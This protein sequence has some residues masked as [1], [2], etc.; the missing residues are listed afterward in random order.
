[1]VL[2]SVVKQEP[3]D[4][5]ESLTM[6]ILFQTAKSARV[7]P[8]GLLIVCLS[9]LG[10]AGTAREVTEA[11]APAAVES[12]VDELHQ[13][14]SRD[15]IG[16]ILQDEE[17]RE[18]SAHLVGAAV[19]GAWDALT[20]EERA[21]R[22]AVA[23]EAYASKLAFT[24]AENWEHEVGPRLSRSF[25]SVLDDSLV[26]LMSEETEARAGAIARSVAREAALG[27]QDAVREAQLKRDGKTSGGADVLATVGD[28]AEATE[29]ALD[30]TPWIIGAV[31]AGLGAGLGFYLARRNSRPSV[32]A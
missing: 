2:A 11:A 17:I 26:R 14:Y 1:M 29:S 22:L 23:T 10:C 30:L 5:D 13:P 7:H 19:G 31:A 24:F 21:E 15:K 18:A 4:D 6:S 27:F 28:A 20:E 8:V 9:A 3:T 16:D 25:Q 12:T 32:P